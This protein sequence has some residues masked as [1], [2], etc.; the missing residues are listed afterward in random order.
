[1]SHRNSQIAL[2]FA[3]ACLG[4]LFGALTTRTIPS[5]VPN[6]VV[7]SAGALLGLCAAALARPVVRNLHNELAR[8]RPSREL[9]SRPGVERGARPALPRTIVYDYGWLGPVMLWAGIPFLGLAALVAAASLVVLVVLPFVPYSMSYYTLAALPAAPILALV[10]VYWIRMV[11]D[12]HIFTTRYELTERGIVIHER[13]GSGTSLPWEAITRGTDARL[14]FTIRLQADALRKDVVLMGPPPRY[15]GMPPS[16]IRQQLIE[17]I[18]GK[19][20]ERS[21]RDKRRLQ[22]REEHPSHRRRRKLRVRHLS[23]D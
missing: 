19:L 10:V 21:S 17:L 12:R 2:H 11:R 4:G 22:L 23:G 6:W 15:A 1:M 9:L 13:S 20:G 3:G 8:H 7:I 18:G 16:A 14:L 5:S